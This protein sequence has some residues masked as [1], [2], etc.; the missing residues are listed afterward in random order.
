MRPAALLR[1]LVLLLSDKER[2]PDMMG[3]RAKGVVC[4]EGRGEKRARTLLS[5]R[6]VQTCVTVR[7]CWLDASLRPLIFTVMLH[8]LFTTAQHQHTIHTIICTHPNNTHSRTPMGKKP[9]KTPARRA[10]P[11]SVVKKTPAATKT[12]AKKKSTVPN[13][14]DL[15]LEAVRSL[16][17]RSGSSLVAIKKFIAS[18]YTVRGGRGQ[19]HRR[20]QRWW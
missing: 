2:R 8:V 17:A 19:Q 9:G 10:A 12:I 13:S 11:V 4:S 6:Q 7:A 1:R 3:A 16:A 14:S 5:G 15:V 18:Q 20:L